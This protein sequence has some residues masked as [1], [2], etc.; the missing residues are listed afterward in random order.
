MSFESIETSEYDNE[1]RELYWFMRGSQSWT[2]TSGQHRVN[3][4]GQ[5]F[6]PVDGLS[7]SS[8]RDSKERSRS[9]MTVSMPRDIEV[10]QMFVGI[11]DTQAMW[12][13]LYRIHDGE[14]EYRLSWQGRVRYNEFQG[15]GAKLTLDNILTS[16]KKSALRH[17]FQNQCNHFT[18]DANC[19]LSEA[20][21][22]TDD[23]AITDIDGN[24]LEVADSQAAGYYRAGQVKR[25]NGDR[26]FIVANT[27]ASGVHT[28]ELLTPFEDLEIG[29]EVTIIGGACLHTFA[30]CPIQVNYGGFP[31]VPR[32]NPFKSFH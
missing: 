5:T 4:E 14:T 7:R 20:T 24:F 26:R 10:A 6:A 30:T 32:K 23:V 25:A 9:Q 27:K 3:F 8:V 31:K 22:S 1:P 29:E 11:P 21:Y 12:L 19:G 2:Y 13:Y 28:F 15:T 18:F 16:T 17:L